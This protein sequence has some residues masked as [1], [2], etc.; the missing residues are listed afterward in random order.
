M[1]K[2]QGILL[3]TIAIVLLGVAIAL[4]ALNV[5]TAIT[6]NWL[7]GMR[8]ELSLGLAFTLVT[9]LVAFSFGCWAWYRHLVL[10]KRHQRTHRE[11]ER[12]DVSSE[13]AESQVKVL[14]QKIQTL[15]KALSEALKR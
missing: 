15:E 6:L 8:W 7:N 3:N 5:E 14:E 12:K 9:V 2:L 10:E 1:F 13:A 11:L 4:I